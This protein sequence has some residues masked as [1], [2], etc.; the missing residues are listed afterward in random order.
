MSGQVVDPSQLKRIRVQLGYTQAALAQAAGVSQSVI[1]KIEAGKVDPTYRTISEISR[2]LFSR[3]AKKSKRASD[4]M[5]SPVI[6]VQESVVLSECVEVM[7][8]NSISQ[9]P[10]FS[11]R[12]M[13]GTITEG[14]IMA[15]VSEAA[16]P[17]AVLG[18]R[19]KDHVL[20]AFA[21]VGKDTPVEALMSLFRL[22]PAVLVSSGDEIVGIVTKI[23]VLSAA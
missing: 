8:R 21:I 14:Q 19:V 6:G 20:P 4:V 18:Q 17:A 2:A 13:A 5:S 16:D 10:V 11:G 23:D 7:K 15:T 3:M 12:R 1:A 22:L 9:M